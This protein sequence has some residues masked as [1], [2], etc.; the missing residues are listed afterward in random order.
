MLGTRAE[1]QDTDQFIQFQ[2][3]LKD[4]VMRELKQ[5]QEIV[6]VV[7]DLKDPVQ[8]LCNNIPKLSKMLKEFGLDDTNTNE[9]ENADTLEAIK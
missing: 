8:V 2:E 1:R 9:A 3:D 6:V 7:K 4:Y 5:P